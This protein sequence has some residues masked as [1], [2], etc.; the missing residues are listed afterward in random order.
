MEAPA[1]G[2]W[3]AEG[4]QSLCHSLNLLIDD[5]ADGDDDNETTT[6]TV[7]IM[8]QFCALFCFLSGQ[9]NY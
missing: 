8:I 9:V 2:K 3:T 1:V 4:K 6:M 5:D 7:V